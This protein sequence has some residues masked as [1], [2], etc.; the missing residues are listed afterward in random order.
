MSVWTF[1]GISSFMHPV[2]LWKQSHF[3]TWNRTLQSYPLYWDNLWHKLLINPSKSGRAL[4]PRSTQFLF[5]E[6]WGY[7]GNDHH[8]TLAC[9]ASLMIFSNNIQPAAKRLLLR[10]ATS[11]IAQDYHKTDEDLHSSNTPNLCFFKQMYGNKYL[12][13]CILAAMQLVTFSGWEKKENKPSMLVSH[14]TL[15]VHKDSL[16]TWADKKSESK[17]NRIIP[18]DAISFS[19]L[20]GCNEK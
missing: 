5:K 4:L 16:V 11:N 10:H 17:W 15:K 6:K 8:Q 14:Y 20:F 19:I 3:H 9:N 12:I 18:W 2:N 7:S 1:A 13:I